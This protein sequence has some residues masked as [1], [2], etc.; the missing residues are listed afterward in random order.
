MPIMDAN[1][2]FVTEWR[3]NTEAVKKSFFKT[4]M[5][6][7]GTSFALIATYVTARI[8]GWNA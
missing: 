2:R 6:V 3:E 1:H 8:K 5:W 7:L 4:L